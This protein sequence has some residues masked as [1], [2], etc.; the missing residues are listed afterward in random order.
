MGYV[1]TTKMK[2]II[3]KILV[4]FLLIFSQTAKSQEK[5][6]TLYLKNSLKL[7]LIS[8]YYTFFDSRIQ[9]RAGFEYERKISSKSFLSGYLDIGIYDKYVFKKYYD[10]F[11]Q[12]QGM[13]FIQQDVAVK[14]FHFIPSYNYFI[15]Q[16]KRKINHGIFLGGNI[17]FNFYRKKLDFFNSQSSEKYSQKYNQSKIALGLSM[18]WKYNLNSQMAIEL[19]S[20]LFACIFKNKSLEN[21]SYIRPLIS[22][23][24]DPKYNFWWVSNLIICYAF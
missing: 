24:N 10:L 5:K 1:T 12:N 15:F 23:W 2:V 14:G 18:G 20:S 17:D 8:L 11:N 21:M 7:D 6:D 3:L 19:K 4:I 13:Y 9:V 22:Q 16:S